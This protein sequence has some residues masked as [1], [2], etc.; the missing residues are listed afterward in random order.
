[1]RHIIAL[2]SVTLATFG[3]LAE[4]KVLSAQDLE[5]EFQ[6]IRAARSLKADFKQTRLIEKWQTEIKT[7]GTFQLTNPPNSHVIWQ[8]NS[9]SYLAFKLSPGGIATQTEPKKKWKPVDAK[10]I[11]S[12]MDNLLSWL[13]FDAKKIAQTHKVTQLQKK[14]FQ[15]TPIDK[16]APIKNVEIKLG[17]DSFPEKM[18]LATPEGD[19]IS[20]HFSNQKVI[21]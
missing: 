8:V 6:P 7:E 10:N 14:L 15:L 18:K 9:P 20:I 3:A 5:R 16:K 13:Q 12:H 17:D 11:Q 19:L 1:M 2:I 21:K 4:E